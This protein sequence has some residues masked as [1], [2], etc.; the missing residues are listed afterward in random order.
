VIEC[1][2]YDIDA[3]GKVTAVHAN[4]FP[5][6]KSGTPE[7]NN[8]KVK[9]NL[10]WVSAKEG[11]KAEIRV[12]DHL[13]TDPHPDS[14]DKN[15]L[16]AINQDSKQILHAYLEP[17]LKN[18]QAEQRFQFERHGYFVADRSDHTAANPVFN[19]CVGLKDTWK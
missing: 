1:T 12:Y 10:H 18:A 11:I 19:L 8:Y 16:D 15:F 17:S 4:Y 14:G 5:D 2:G 13:F 9:G 7:S 3:N 6:S